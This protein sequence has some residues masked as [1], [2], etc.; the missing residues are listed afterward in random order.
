[1][2][3][4][5]EGKLHKETMPHTMLMESRNTFHNRGKENDNPSPAQTA[6]SITNESQRN[7]LFRRLIMLMTYHV[8]M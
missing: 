6:S 8:H 3:K 1:M 2:N 4:R 5:P 7:G